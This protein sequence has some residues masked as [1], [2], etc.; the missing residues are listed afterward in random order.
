MRC[1]LWQGADAAPAKRPMTDADRLR[2]LA[3]MDDVEEVG[4]AVL[5]SS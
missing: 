4:E 1:A 3:K 5:F 2:M